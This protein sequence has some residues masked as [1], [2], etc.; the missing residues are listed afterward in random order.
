MTEQTA[1]L[2]NQI[3]NQAGATTPYE[4]AIAIQN[5]LRSNFTYQLDAGGAPDGRDIVDYFLFESKVGRCDHFASSMAVM[6]RTL[7]VPA[8]RHR[9]RSGAV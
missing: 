1:D 2:A 3:V 4:Q 6:L 9:A 5:Y 8:N 7:G